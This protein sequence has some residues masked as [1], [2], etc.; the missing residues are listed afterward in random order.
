MSHPLTSLP[1]TSPQ[2]SLVGELMNKFGFS[3]ILE[4]QVKEEVG[5][6]RFIML[7]FRRR[8]RRQSRSPAPVRRLLAS[9]RRWRGPRGSRR[10]R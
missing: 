4:Y 6:R 2:H 3:D 7:M 8:T 5:R 9:R 1:Q 10:S